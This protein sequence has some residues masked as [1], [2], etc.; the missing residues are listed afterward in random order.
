[1]LGNRCGGE[2]Q[3]YSQELWFWVGCFTFLSAS[4][5]LPRHQRCR[6][7]KDACAGCRCDAGTVLPRLLC[8][9]PLPWVC[10][11]PRA[12]TAWCT[13]ELL[14]LTKCT[15]Q[16]CCSRVFNAQERALT[17]QNVQED[18]YC[19][20]QRHLFLHMQRSVCMSSL[21]RALF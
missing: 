4:F 21:Y 10:E 13:P 3:L 20:C 1:M 14:V 8:S 5:L 12:K 16:S 6:T 15:A 11:A 7:S 9:L 18:Y 2:G 17:G 19:L